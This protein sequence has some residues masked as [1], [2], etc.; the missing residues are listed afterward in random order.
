MKKYPTSFRGWRMAVAIAIGLALFASAPASWAANYN[1]VDHQLK[2]TKPLP[3]K[4]V[5]T[6][7]TATAIGAK[8]DS[9]ATTDTGTFSLISLFKRALQKLTSVDDRLAGTLNTVNIVSATTVNSTALEAS[10]VLKAS[11]G[12]L[13]SFSV[14]NTKASAQ[15][16][17]IMNSAT[18]PA[19]GA[20]TLLYPP[21]YVPATSNAMLTFPIPLTASTGIAVSNSS[22]GTFTKTI[23]AAD[24]IFNGQV[25]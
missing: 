24:C 23:G 11:A 18:V 20:V 13:V 9:A 5:A 15:Y 8:N 16:I 4:E 7:P 21:I 22:T 17:L 6:G 25:Q 1:I 2:E 10:K 19:D 3:V 14:F 12:S